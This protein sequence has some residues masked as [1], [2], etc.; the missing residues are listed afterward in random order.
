MKATAQLMKVTTGSLRM[1]LVVA[2]AVFQQHNAAA[3]IT[4]GTADSFAVLAGAGITVTGPVNSTTITGDIGSFGSSTAI[5][6]LG[7]VVLTGTNHAG[8]AVT[9][10][11]KID[12]GIA[13]GV[14]AGEPATIDYGAGDNQLG[15]K[16]LFPGV[17]R[18]GE[19]STANLIGALTLDPNG[20]ANPVWI[21]Q[22]T[23]TLVTASNSSVVLMPGAT[24]CDVLW[25]VGS[26]ATL[27]TGTDFVGTIMASASIGLDTGATLHGRAWAETASVTLDNNTITGLPCTSLGGAEVVGTSVPDSGSTLLLLGSGLATLLGFRRRFRSLV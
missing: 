1:G 9:Q 4:Y 18:F 27:G 6:G 19:A 10:G 24:P 7:N 20:V 11:A 21:F 17:Y 5:T 16:F 22:A 12:L 25:V 26:S 3:Q 15:G 23:S 14:A 2:A 8:D 13:Y